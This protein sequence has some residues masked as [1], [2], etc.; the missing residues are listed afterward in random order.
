MIV[1][2]LLSMSANAALTP[3]TPSDFCM[4]G[5]CLNDDVE[6]HP[7]LKKM[8]LR[9]YKNINNKSKC[10]SVALNGEGNTTQSR[11][12]K[13]FVYVQPYVTDNGKLSLRI[14]SLKYTPKNL[15]SDFLSD[16]LNDYASKYE[17]LLKDGDSKFY[18]ENSE[19][20]VNI[21]TWTRGLSIQWIPSNSFEKKIWKDFERAQISCEEK[22]NL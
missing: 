16:L 22:P 9:A 11:G 10:N 6:K 19:Q 20:I 7:E 13:I 12:N 5:F 21:H 4:S 2:L 17:G 18:W 8:F 1:S 14:T 3:S 15:S